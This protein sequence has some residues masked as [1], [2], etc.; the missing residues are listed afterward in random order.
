ML[1]LLIF[2]MLII[3]KIKTGVNSFY[4]IKKS[5]KLHHAL[6]IL[7]YGKHMNSTDL[8]HYLAPLQGVEP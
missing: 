3:T 2:Y 7:V 6:T 8:H 5:A 4:C 1:L